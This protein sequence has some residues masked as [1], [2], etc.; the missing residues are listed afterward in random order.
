MRVYFATP[1]VKYRNK[2]NARSI[3]KILTELKLQIVN[4]WVLWDDPNPK[5]D[6]KKI[7]ARD[8][9]AIK[10]CDVFVADITKPSTGIG[11]E[12]M[13]AKKFNKKIICVHKGAI[14]S[15]MVLGMPGI[16]VIRYSDMRYLREQLRSKTAY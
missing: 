15:N 8:I 7:Y 9:N 1:L 4:E 5:L 14:V 10:K 3:N 16:V 12:I 2:Q 13:A 11:I 6:S